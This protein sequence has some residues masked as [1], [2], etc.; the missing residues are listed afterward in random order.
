MSVGAATVRHSALAVVVDTDVAGLIFAIAGIA[1][2]TLSMRWA[3]R[4]P[5]VVIALSLVVATVSGLWLVYVRF[6]L[7]R[8]E[9]LLFASG[10]ET[11][12]GTLQIPRRGPPARA[13]VLVHGSGPE[14]RDRYLFYVRWLAEHGIAAFA[15]DKRGTGESSGTLYESTYR[16]YAA[17]AA[18]AVDAVAARLGLG[19]RSI[20][21]VGFSEAEWVAPLTAAQSPLIG[22]VAI[23][24]AS[25]LSPAG[26]VQAELAL[27]LERRGYDAATISQALNLN[28]RVLEYQRTGAGAEDLAA[29]LAN[30]RSQ[31]WFAD[32]E[33]IPAEMHPP[34]VYAWW[35]SVMDFDAA[36]AWSR[37]EVPV[38]L[39]KGGA[40]DRSTA[41]VMRTRIGHALAAAGHDQPDVVVFPEADHMLLEWPLGPGVPPPVF[42]EGALE[43][44]LAWIEEHS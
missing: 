13:I 27:R 36:A 7:S 14:R 17:D 11:L 37:V 6:T 12:S 5:R 26:Q 42:A 8:S 16:D 43:H 15:Y 34:E 20:G 25:G 38:L 31:P 32:A 22:Y 9:G 30:A 33:D 28:S 23:I 24:G 44:L 3:P 2:L 41:G 29:S 4:P 18:A 40:D 10:G 39:L 19:E 35:R 21:L 1:L